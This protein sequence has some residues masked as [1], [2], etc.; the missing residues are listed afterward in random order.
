MVLTHAGTET[1]ARHDELAWPLADDG[2]EID[3]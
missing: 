1:L 2:T 3:I